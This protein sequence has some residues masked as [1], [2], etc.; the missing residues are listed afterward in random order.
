MQIV[1]TGGS[2]FIGQRLASALLKSVFPFEELILS[3]VVQ[4]AAP[5]RDPRVRCVCVDLSQPGAIQHL[6]T[7][8]TSTVFHL[9]AIVSSH[10]ESDFDLGWRVNMD[11]T[12][13][14]LEACRRNPD[15]RFVF[16]SS[17]AVY[18]GQLPAIVDDRTAVTPQSSY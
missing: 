8:R 11:I 14:L 9:A 7:D 6:I 4:P 12:R 17:L 18:G 3:D 2:G 15:I 16:A 1:I 10:A 5:L 13:H